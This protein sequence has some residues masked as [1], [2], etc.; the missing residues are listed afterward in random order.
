MDT[1]L[2]Y[3]VI[4]A[5]SGVLVGGLATWFSIAQNCAKDQELQQLNRQLAASDEKTSTLQWKES[6]TGKRIAHSKG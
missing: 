5:L 2:L 3:A 4:G 1:S 6:M